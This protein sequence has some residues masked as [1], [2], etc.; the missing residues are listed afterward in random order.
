MNAFILIQFRIVFSSFPY[1]KSKTMF[2]R[3]LNNFFVSIDQLGNVLA[4]GNPD[5]T[6][7]SRVGYYNKHSGLNEKA[8]WQ[9]RVFE[10]IINFTFYPIDGKDHCHEAFHNDAGEEFDNKTKNVVV[11][12]L[13]AFIIIPSCLLISIL[14]YTLYAFGVVSPKFI[15]R[16]KNIKKRLNL[17]QA[18]LDGTLHELNEHK[19]YIDDELKEAAVKTIESAQNVHDKING[20]LNL[21][22]RVKNQ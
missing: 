19:V 4:G 3:Y 16:N 5:N 13:A 17:A 1:F 21:R 2:M 20:M 10:K 14:L 18:K 6:I 22:E 8:P 9:W 12:I 7:S 11:A 15:D